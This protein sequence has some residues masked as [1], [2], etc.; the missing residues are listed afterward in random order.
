MAT[1]YHVRVLAVEGDR[2]VCHVTALYPDEPLVPSR[3]LAFRFVWEPWYNLAE[4]VTQHLPGG[5]QGVTSE[6]A[7]GM[8]RRQPLAKELAGQDMD[9]LDWWC[10]NADRFIRCVG[11]TDLVAEGA[12]ELG[13]RGSEPGPQAT[14][15]I[16]ATD[17]RYRAPDHGDGVGD[18]RL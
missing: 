6:E 8:R 12:A 16:L 13:P 10:A 7:R 11:V 5:G 1:M 9:D 18:D 17:S 14:Y 2:L 4:G 3:T 15:T